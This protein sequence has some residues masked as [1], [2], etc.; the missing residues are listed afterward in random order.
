MSDFGVLYQALLFLSQCAGSAFVVLL[1]S[2]HIYYQRQQKH[3]AG[4]RLLKYQ[5]WQIPIPGGLRLDERRW[6][7]LNERCIAAAHMRLLMWGSSIHLHTHAG[8]QLC[9]CTHD[10]ESP[11]GFLEEQVDT[12][13]QTV[14]DS[15][16]CSSAY[17]WGC[18]ANRLF[19]LYY[20]SGKTCMLSGDHIP[21]EALHPHTYQCI[22]HACSACPAVVLL[23]VGIRL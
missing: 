5:A 2:I 23:P 16:S 14:P 9:C 17:V 19:V 10:F 4:E 12:W 7:Y 18:V 15:I 11:S 20:T 1:H 22:P 13:H 21:G 6:F 8:R 3:T